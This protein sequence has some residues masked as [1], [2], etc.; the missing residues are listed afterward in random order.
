M[1][2]TGMAVATAA[3]HTDSALG[4]MVPGSMGN[5]GLA[6]L[7]P[8]GFDTMGK[9]G[10]HMSGLDS[11]NNSFEQMLNDGDLSNDASTQEYLNGLL[12]SIGV[13]GQDFSA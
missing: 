4:L 13:E 1:A 2:S 8:A 5:N 6:L 3:G 7:S 10:G 11:S 9:M 12:A